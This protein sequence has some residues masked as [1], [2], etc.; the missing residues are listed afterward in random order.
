MSFLGLLF[1]I[2]IFILIIGVSVV[3]SVLRAIFGLGK[4]RGTSYQRPNANS[5]QSSSQR[6][7]QSKQTV[8]DPQ[9]EHKK[10]FD[11]NEGEYVEFEEVKEE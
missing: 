1:F 2:I 7:Q 8:N 11:K 3:V 6:Q 5:S 10:V 9:K 4:R